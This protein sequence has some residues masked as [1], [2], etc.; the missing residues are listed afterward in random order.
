MPPQNAGYMYTAY[1]AAAVIYGGYALSI[2][3]RAR[4]LARRVRKQA[5]APP[6]GRRY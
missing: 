3:L 5:D 1:A 2:W 4:G 6:P